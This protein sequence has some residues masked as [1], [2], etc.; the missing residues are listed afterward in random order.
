M[1]LDFKLCN[2]V[3][4]LTDRASS[5]ANQGAITINF[6]LVAADVDVCI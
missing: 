5:D 2:R 3:E 1:C 4:E 6:G